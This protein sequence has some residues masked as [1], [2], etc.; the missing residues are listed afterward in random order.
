MKFGLQ[1]IR[2]TFSYVI[3]KKKKKKGIIWQP[4]TNG[5]I[6]VVTRVRLQVVI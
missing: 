1:L 4:R 2:L 3:Q 6:L 5:P